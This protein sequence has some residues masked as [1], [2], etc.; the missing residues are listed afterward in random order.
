MPKYYQDP[1]VRT[2]ISLVA[3]S[4]RRYYVVFST[5]PESH[6]NNF[7]VLPMQKTR[8]TSQIHAS[9]GL[10]PSLVRGT[11]LVCCIKTEYPYYI[12]AP[13][14]LFWRQFYSTPQ[15]CKAKNLS[16]S[17]FCFLDLNGSDRRSERINPFLVVNSARDVEHHDGQ[18]R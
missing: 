10:S 2:Y 7:K 12:I 5:R 18:Q 3:S 11:L 13:Q 1:F 8:K 15:G 16:S 4:A 6:R 9:D 17:V 14:C